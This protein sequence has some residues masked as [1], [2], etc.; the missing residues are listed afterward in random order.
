M[1]IT[2]PPIFWRFLSFS[3][4]AGMKEYTY[5]VAINWVEILQK[6]RLAGVMLKNELL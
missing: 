6:L 3:V 2:L 1:A 5:C 4:L